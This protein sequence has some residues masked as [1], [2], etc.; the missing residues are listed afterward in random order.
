M[1]HRTS[2]ER[3]ALFIN[4]A[5][6]VEL[7][8]TQILEARTDDMHD[9]PANDT[10]RRELERTKVRTHSLE[11]ALS[12]IGGQVDERQSLFAGIGA[13]LKAVVDTF[14]D[15]A[16]KALL[17]FSDDFVTAQG[18]IASYMV[19]ESAAG[20]RE[21]NDLVLIAQQHRKEV[22]ETAAWFW[23]ELQHLAREGVDPDGVSA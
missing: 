6:A 14:R 21:N 16:L 22:E 2:D 11:Q 7:A 19:I 4:R 10:L 1:T 8:L 23:L 9:Q 3:L 17:D 15:D 20:A 13:N 5:I 12:A 18:L